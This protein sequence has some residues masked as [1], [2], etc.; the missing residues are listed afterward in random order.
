MARINAHHLGMTPINSHWSL[1]TLIPVLILPL[2]PGPDL[3]KIA[4]S[5]VKRISLLRVKLTLLG[6]YGSV[7]SH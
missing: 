6:P 4:K 5:E 1:I 3:Q 7:A 2:F